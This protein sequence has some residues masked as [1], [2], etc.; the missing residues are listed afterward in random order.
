[1]DFKSHSTGGK[2][3]LIYFSLG[4]AD[5]RSKAGKDF[6]QP[7][8]RSNECWF[9][10]I[11]TKKFT[12][13]FNKLSWSFQ[14][15]KELKK[16]LWLRA[17][18][19]T[20]LWHLKTTLHWRLKKMLI[21]WCGRCRNEFESWQKRLLSNLKPTRWKTTCVVFDCHKKLRAL[22]TKDWILF[23]VFN[24]KKKIKKLQLGKLGKKNHYCACVLDD[25]FVAQGIR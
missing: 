16:T 8:L 1:M 5:K 13:P 4:N 3:L 2:K 11:V 25:H 6:W 7:S 12:C 24:Q 20:Q 18:E 15:W 14:H 22:S 19:A 23:N 21:S 10:L 9:C 17:L